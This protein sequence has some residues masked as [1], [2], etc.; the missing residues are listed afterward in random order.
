MGLILPCPYIKYDRDE[1]WGKDKNIV[2]AV[3][4][5]V[6]PPN[7]LNCTCYTKDACFKTCPHYLELSARGSAPLV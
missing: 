2:C 6:I 1:C 7:K 5:E 4:N 3:T